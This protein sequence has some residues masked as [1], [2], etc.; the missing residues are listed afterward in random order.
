M[1]TAY[2]R[3]HKKEFLYT[4]DIKGASTFFRC[5]VADEAVLLDVLSRKF[6]GQSIELVMLTE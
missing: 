4:E 5:M 6:P 2:Y 3:K 1:I